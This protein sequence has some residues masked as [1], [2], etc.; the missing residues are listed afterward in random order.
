MTR[1]VSRYSGAGI[2]AGGSPVR[3][4]SISQW[5]SIQSLEPIT[6]QITIDQLAAWIIVGALAGSL[7][8]LLVTRKKEGF[9]YG[10]NLAVG[11]AGA[12]IGGLLFKL[13]RINLGVLGAVSISA[14]DIIEGLLGSLLLLGIIWIVKRQMAKK[15]EAAAKVGHK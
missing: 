14:E 4:E 12:L 11:L 7:A 15:N 3:R 10:L 5:Q 1:G 2:E 9:G 8:G 13:L 6:M